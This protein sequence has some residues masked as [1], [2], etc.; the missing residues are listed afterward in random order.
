M[1]L[2]YEEEEPNEGTTRRRGPTLVGTLK[3]TFH[4]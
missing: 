3:G 1:V 4:W 2:L